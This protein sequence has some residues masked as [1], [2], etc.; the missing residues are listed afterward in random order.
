M[1]EAVGFASFAGGV[2]S[3]LTQFSLASRLRDWGIARADLSRMVTAVTGNV[4][5]DPVRAANAAHLLAI[6][7]DA[8]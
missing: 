7:E 6:Y 2:D 4:E 3:L 5:N 8:H 1:S